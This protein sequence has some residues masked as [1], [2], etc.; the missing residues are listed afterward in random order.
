MAR[1]VRLVNGRDNRANLYLSQSRT[2]RFGKRQ[3][4][5]VATLRIQN[6]WSSVSSRP[7][8]PIGP[9]C[10]SPL[11]FMKSGAAWTDLAFETPARSRDNIGFW[12]ALAE[13]R[14]HNRAHWERSPRHFLPVQIFS[15]NRA[16]SWLGSLGCW[17]RI[18]R[19]RRRKIMGEENNKLE[20]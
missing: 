13:V 14:P 1:L 20:K 17:W 9:N 11:R 7:L 5:F 2:R 12:K 8:N 3:F 4:S 10:N 16:Q 6:P 19:E 15:S 18:R